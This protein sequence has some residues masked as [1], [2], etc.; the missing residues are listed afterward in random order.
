MLKKMSIFALYVI[1][2]TVTAA[3]PVRKTITTTDG[4][5]RE[6]MLYMPQTAGNEKPAGI[7]VALHGY[8]SS[9]NTFFSSYSITTV[10][11]ALNFIVVSP[12]ALP[13]QNNDTK[14]KVEQVNALTGNKLT[15]D[16]VWG[17]GLAVKATFKLL[18]VT[19]TFIDNELNRNVDDVDFIRIVI[20]KTLADYDM[21]SANIFLTGTSMGGYMAYRYAL[22]M[23]IRI[24]G[25]IS[26]T[27][28]MGTRLTGEMNR[29][30]K[31]PICD[32]HSIDDEV[33]PYNGT[34]KDGGFDI[35]LA[36]KMSDVIDYWVKTNGA[37]NAITETVDYYPST[38][39]FT[40]EKI[41]YP[42]TANGN[43]VIHYKM[44][45]A[46]HS[47]FLRKETDCMDYLEE[48]IKFINAHA[49]TDTNGNKPAPSNAL[50]AP[51]PA[52]GTVKFNV[53]DGIA[54][55]YDLS[56]RKALTINIENS[57][58]DVSPL[59]P[60]VYAVRIISSGK[61]FTS[62]LIKR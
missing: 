36:L 8:N 30:N 47:D 41:T 52:Y 59:K 2:I 62:K 28:S 48:I 38:R 29:L 17:C 45:G 40:A 44:T 11:D 31:T 27:G 19:F 26:I 3:E 57:L 54:E 23:P 37:G 58:G 32:F 13:E 61:I 33:V 35:T 22:K 6:Y 39:G 20:E 9:M 56:G 50:I 16:A 42:A 49:I 4:L 10:A 25:L 53:N 51:N 24:A 34:Y 55:F 46:H 14:E 18:G 60:G 1:A 5:N 21:S 15:L 7:I 12:Q 43:E